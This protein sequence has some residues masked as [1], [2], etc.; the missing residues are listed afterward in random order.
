[1]QEIKRFY[2]QLYTSQGKVGK[3]YLQTLQIP[4]ISKEMRDELEMPITQEEVGAALLK[5]ANGKCPSM[6]GLDASFYKVF[7]SLLK[8]FLV[9]LFNEVVREGELH[10]T[11]RES[12]ISLIEKLYKDP[13]RLKCW[14]PISLLNTD[15]KLY[16]KILANRLQKAIGNLIHHSQQGFMEGRLMTEN[17]LKI[18]QVMQYCEDQQVDAVLINYD[19]LNA[20]DMVEWEAIY[21]TLEAMN[22]GPV[23]ISMVRTLLKNPIAY[24][25]NN[26]MWAEPIFLT[27]GCRQGCCYAPKIFVTVVELLGIAIR[28]N[29][30]IRGI[31]INTT[32]IKAG[33]FADDLWTTTEATPQSVNEILKELNKF[34]KYSGLRINPEKC[35]VLRLGPFRITQAKFYTMKQ[36][37][38]SDGPIRILGSQIFPD[39]KVMMQENYNMILNTVLTILEKWRKCDLTLFCKVTIVN[40]LI[41]SL[42]VHKLTALP[43]PPDT[44][45][46]NYKR[47]ILEF[48]WGNKPARLK[49]ERLVQNYEHYGLKLADLK[50]KGHCAK[51][52]I[53]L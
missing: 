10:R 15:N 20:F 52:L 6:D 13:L 5:L 31:T 44:F 41:N 7:Y 33:Q 45:F 22:F 43:T 18:Q 40:T 28:Q 29:P 53:A 47:T 46:V 32:K 39:K 26:G 25:S 42:F 38:W 14:R 48:V 17:V 1:M 11:A 2:D 4:Q 51:S 24:I 12:I 35:A 37:F 27:R 9:D 19:F 49:Y 36:L 3:Q 30:E 16:G 21:L 23:Y 8:D 34:Q 50:S